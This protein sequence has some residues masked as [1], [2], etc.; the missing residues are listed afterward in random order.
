MDALDRIT[1][2]K[3]APD[4]QREVAR[5]DAELRTGKTALRRLRAHDRA[6]RKFERRRKREL[7]RE[8]RRNRKERRSELAEL[9][10]DQ[11]ERMVRMRHVL[12]PG[13]PK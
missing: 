1:Y 10:S 8:I 12:Y 2:D 13:N 5:L 4:E 9:R 11:K 6:L 7:R 3:L